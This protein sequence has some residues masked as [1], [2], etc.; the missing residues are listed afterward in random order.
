MRCIS[1]R[2]GRGMFVFHV[3]V[4]CVSRQWLSHLRVHSM[5]SDR[6]GARRR[7]THTHT[8]KKK[9]LN[10]ALCSVVHLAAGAVDGFL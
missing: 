7:K 3:N 1:G 2:A 8:P 10:V 6:V 5:H 9:K 4:A